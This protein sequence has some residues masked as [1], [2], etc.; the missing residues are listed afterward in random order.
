MEV[1]KCISLFSEGAGVHIDD[2]E[3]LKEENNN[4]KV[5]TN[6]IL[7]DTIFV[8]LFRNICV[9]LII[10]TYCYVLIILCQ[11]VLNPLAVFED[12]TPL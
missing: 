10:F 6:H 11:V 5:K 12:Q 9:C 4:V 7:Q 2:L 3:K 8:K 1:V